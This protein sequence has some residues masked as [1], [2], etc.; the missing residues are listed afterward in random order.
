MG[1]P[2]YEPLRPND[3]FFLHAEALGAHQHVGGLAVLDPSTRPDGPVRLEEISARLVALLDEL[4]RLRQRL[5]VPWG[6][7][8]RPAWVDAA[9]FS[10]SRH[11][12]SLAVAAPGDRRELER[13]VE[14]VMSR[15][16]DRT[17]PLWEL[18]LLEGL[19]GGGQAVLIKL[20]HAI[21]DAV[22]VLVVAERLLDADAGPRPPPAAGP[23]VPAPAPGGL[24]LFGRTLAHQ[25]ASPWRDLF[26]STRHALS[27]PR[28]AW[29]R[30][31]R[32]VAG[33]WQLARAGSAP[34]TPLNQTVGSGRRIVLTETRREDLQAAHRADGGTDND[35]VLAAV[36][37][38]L[39]K[40]FA[41]HVDVPPEQLRTMVP[42]SIRRG[43]RTAP[44]TWTSTLD[45]D[46]PIGAMAPR[47]RLRAVT[48]ATR[49]AKRSD[50]SIGS[51]FVMSAVGTWAVP[52][53]HARFARFAYRGKWFNLIVSSVPGPRGARYLAGARV[54]TAYPIIPLAEGVGLT[55]AAMNWNEHVTFGLT[56]DV[57]QIDDLDDIAASMV[58]YVD[59]LANG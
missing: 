48:A 15:P 33:V 17:R 40:W 20:H 53:V 23:W 45:L 36:A 19:A 14:T 1:P 43:H 47:E 21:A 9:D 29:R 44:G 12:R 35:V 57:E 24:E 37:G 51:Q 11:V 18:V 39:Q 56:A 7:L 58:A 26:G 27:D 59:E 46:L 50:Q 30:G 52:L 13:A 42:V 41:G 10:M 55:V 22:G 32:T 3:V 28:H 6:G 16:L 4:P 25:V 31:E 38:A 8:A 54:V 5:A 49:R 2:H 34:P